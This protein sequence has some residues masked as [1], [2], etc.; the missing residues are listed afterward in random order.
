[1]QTL[2]NNYE[3]DKLQLMADAGFDVI[4]FTAATLPVE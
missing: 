1:M 2:A 3:I 4:T